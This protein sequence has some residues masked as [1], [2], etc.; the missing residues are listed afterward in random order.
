[1]IET[2]EEYPLLLEAERRMEDAKTED[3]IP[4]EKVLS[5]LGINRAL[6]DETDVVLK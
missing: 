5:E 6:L 4:Q 3:F 1:M 2:I